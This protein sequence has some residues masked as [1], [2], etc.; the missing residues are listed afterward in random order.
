VIES[1]ILEMYQ[2]YKKGSSL[3]EVGLKNGLSIYP[4]KTAFKKC[5]LRIRS[6]SETRRMKCDDKHK[7]MHDLY[8]TGETLQFVADAYGLASHTAVRN[9]FIRRG[10]ELR[11]AY[12]TPRIEFDGKTYFYN[13]H[14]GYWL[15]IETSKRL[16]RDVYKKHYGSIPKDHVI[17]HI[18]EDKSNNDISNLKAMTIPNHMSHHRLIE[19]L[20]KESE[21]KHKLT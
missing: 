20:V 2:E 6:R 10:Y 9:A 11:K 14:R 17:H 4:V 8:L 18:D 3:R 19:N 15:D 21:Q 5:G 16:H 1:K 13:K 7:A 12:G